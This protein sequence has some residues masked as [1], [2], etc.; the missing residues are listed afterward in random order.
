[1]ASCAMGSVAPMAGVDEWAASA[2]DFRDWAPILG[3]WE[4]EEG[5][6]RYL[7]PPEPDAAFGILLAP[8]TWNLGAGR[9][10][11]RVTFPADE[12]EAEPQGR[13]IFG[14]DSRNQSHFSA[15]LGG[16]NAL[17]VVEAYRPPQGMAPL[18]RQGDPANL[19]RDRE[20]EIVVHLAG[21]S[22]TLDVDGV[23]IVDAPLSSPPLGTQVGLTAWGRANV[24]FSEFTVVR[25]TPRAFV[26]MQFGE[27]YDTLY[28]EVIEP[29][30]ADLGLDAY[31][32][33]EGGPGM[34]LDDIIG[35]IQ[36]ASVVIAEITPAN[37]NV[38]YEVGYSH[39]TDKPTILL[40]EKDCELPF[41]VSGFR[42]IF[43]DDSIGGKRRVEE[44]LRRHL[45]ALFF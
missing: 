30:T 1:M 23:E 29:I 32:A 38:F 14:W 45:E 44:E 2:V 43:Y 18:Q 37:P 42:C 27:P 5:V 36:R 20:Y 25:R 9:V 6:A 15:G 12:A 19:V 21:Q 3:K 13:I 24:E 28:S 33:D 41:D 10:D 31:R 26:V 40:A 35:G 7:G 39:A 4:R 16:W 11:V 8:D 17:F 22:V 34:I